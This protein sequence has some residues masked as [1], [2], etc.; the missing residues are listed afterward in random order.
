MPSD[1]RAYGVTQGPPTPAC[2]L[3]REQIENRPQVENRNTPQGEAGEIRQPS[4]GIKSQGHGNRQY[5]HDEPAEI[6]P[7]HTGRHRLLLWGQRYGR[8]FGSSGGEA[9]QPSIANPAQQVSTKRRSA[10]TDR[11]RLKPKAS[12]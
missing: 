8:L 9:S 5:Q 6:Q 12:R 3:R 10:P 1:D 4:D 7:E 11:Q 2:A